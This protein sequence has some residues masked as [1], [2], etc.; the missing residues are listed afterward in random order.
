MKLITTNTIKFLN[1]NN[2]YHSNNNKDDDNHSKS[3]TFTV[4]FT[5]QEVCADSCCWYND[6][7]TSSGNVPG[8]GETNLS[9]PPETIWPCT[10]KCPL[11]FGALGLYGFQ[12]RKG[13]NTLH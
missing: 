1:E 6:V 5:A 2:Y 4:P 13:K 7:E 9:S 3:I 12:S 11:Q 10:L 8:C